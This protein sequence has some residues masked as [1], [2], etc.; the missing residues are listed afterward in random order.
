M[1]SAESPHQSSLH[2]STEDGP[3]VN[4]AT[5][6]ALVLCLQL[7]DVTLLLFD[8]FVVVLTTAESSRRLWAGHPA[9]SHLTLLVTL[10]RGGDKGGV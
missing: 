9:V 8:P 6:R 10:L 2:S 5:T 4:D 7:D 3:P 1:I